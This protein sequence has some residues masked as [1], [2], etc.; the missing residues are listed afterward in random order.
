[1]RLSFLGERQVNSQSGEGH[2]EALVEAVQ[3]PGRTQNLVPPDCVGK[4]VGEG[5]QGATR[6]SEDPGAPTPFP[7]AG[8]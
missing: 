1:M 5:T 6:R 7:E 3:E 8:R 2:G 4:K